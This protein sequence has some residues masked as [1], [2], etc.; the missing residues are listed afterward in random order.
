MA[1]YIDADALIE[2]TRAHGERIAYVESFV[3]D[4]KEAPTVAM[5]DDHIT[6]NWTP[7]IDRLAREVAYQGLNQFSFL[8]KS[9]REWVEIILEQTAPVWTSVKDGL[10]AVMGDYLTRLS[11][12]TYRILGYY[13]YIDFDKEPRWL[14]DC[15]AEELVE[16]PNVTHWRSLP[17]PPEEEHGEVD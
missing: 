16:V 2:R 1:R 6:I 14:E 13:D 12:G 8:G 11:D 15:T 9:I 3:Q 7:D 5:G 10:P 4:I 17:E